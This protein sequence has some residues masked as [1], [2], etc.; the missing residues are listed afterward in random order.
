PTPS[1]RRVRLTPRSLHRLRKH[2]KAGLDQLPEP[3]S[4]IVGEQSAGLFGER[5]GELPAP[6]LPVDLVRRPLRLLPAGFLGQPLPLGLGDLEQLAG[7]F[8]CDLLGPGEA[9]DPVQGELAELDGRQLPDLVYRP[10]PLP[11]QCRLECSPFEPYRL[12][13]VFCQAL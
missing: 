9:L 6:P 1:V 12:A 11:V 3:R 10:P 5:R 8:V 7:V 13:V 4:L 2:A